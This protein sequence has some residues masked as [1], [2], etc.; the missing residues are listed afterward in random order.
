MELSDF[1]QEK[2]CHKFGL[3]TFNLTVPDA[4]LDFLEKHYVMKMSSPFL[5][6]YVTKH[7]GINEIKDVYTHLE[8]NFQIERGDLIH[9]CDPDVVFLFS[10][11][12]LDEKMT[13]SNRYKFVGYLT[14]H[15]DVI[16]II[17]LHPFIRSKGIISSFLYQ[18]GLKENMV[19][20][21]PPFS[22]SMEGCLEKLENIIKEDEDFLKAQHEFTLR[23]FKKHCKNTSIDTL[24]RQEAFKIREGITVAQQQMPTSVFNDL[25]IGNMIEAQILMLMFLKDNPESKGKN[26]VMI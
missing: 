11:N 20:I 24:S 13:L 4:D 25:G 15:Q 3:S 10:I 26:N 6:Y 8:K 12:E 21:Q 9:Y 22:K 19:A 2:E 7:N 18:Y 14:A 1:L 23:F 16:Q 17:W 5:N